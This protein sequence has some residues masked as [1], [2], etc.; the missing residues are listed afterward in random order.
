MI[1]ILSS[2][3]LNTLSIIYY[4]YLIIIYWFNNVCIVLDLYMQSD[5]VV[6]YNKYISNILL[7]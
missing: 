1:K 2:D 3:V 7:C 5:N 4:K 6:L